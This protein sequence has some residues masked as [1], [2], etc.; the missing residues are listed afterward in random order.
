MHTSHTLKTEADAKAFVHKFCDFFDVV[1]SADKEW[2]YDTLRALYA[3]NV[4]IGWQGQWAQGMKNCFIQWQPVQ[5]AI[6]KA[7]TL[8]FDIQS[9]SETM[10]SFTAYQ[11]NRTWKQKD[12]FVVINFVVDIDRNGHV[13]RQNGTA[14]QKYADLFDDNLG[15]YRKGRLNVQ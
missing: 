11:L 4:Q 8:S 9:F 10:V 3:D 7:R 1:W 6:V 5:H 2:D 14:K 15:A 13:I 12:M